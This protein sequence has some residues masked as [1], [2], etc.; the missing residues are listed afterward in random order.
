[1]LM[2]IGL[3]PARS[4]ADG[5]TGKVFQQQHVE[6]LHSSYSFELIYT[7][8]PPFAKWKCFVRI[9]NTIQLAAIYKFAEIGFA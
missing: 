6:F 4:V 9:D 5:E 8:E 3:P 2:N 1:M 7:S